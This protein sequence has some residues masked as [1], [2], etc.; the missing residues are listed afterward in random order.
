MLSDLS[1]LNLSAQVVLGGC[2]NGCDAGFCI[3][4]VGQCELQLSLLGF[5]LSALLVDLTLKCLVIVQSSPHII[6]QRLEP[7]VQVCSF[8]LDSRV[9]DRVYRKE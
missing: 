1:K 6:L 3:I 9:S 5:E 7:G 2:L 8:R 4:D